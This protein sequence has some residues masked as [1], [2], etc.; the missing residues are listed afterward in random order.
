MKEKLKFG[1]HEHLTGVPRRK[2]VEKIGKGNIKKD[3]A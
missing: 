2:K 1:V 3:K